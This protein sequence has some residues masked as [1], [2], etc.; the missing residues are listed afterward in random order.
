VSGAL[1]APT[2][3]YRVHVHGAWKLTGVVDVSLVATDDISG[4]HDVGCVGWIDKQLVEK[5]LR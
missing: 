4:R 5:S 1:L 2:P 3:G